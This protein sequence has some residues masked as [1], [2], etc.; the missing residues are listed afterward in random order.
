MPLRCHLVNRIRSRRL[1][2]HPMRSF[3]QMGDGWHTSPTS[4]ANI[5]FT[6]NRSQALPPNHRFRLQVEHTPDGTR[7]GKEL[8]YIAADGKLMSVS[9]ETTADA[10]ETT[11][12]P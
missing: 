6:C 12:E 8:C 9:V 7:M 1:S 2:M 11:S 4:P 3:H 10:E 5:R